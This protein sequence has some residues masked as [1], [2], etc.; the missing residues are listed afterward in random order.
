LVWKIILGIVLFFVIVLAVRVRVTVHS[1][2]GIS[3]CVKWLF[4]KFNILPKDK[5]KPKKEKKKK[6]KKEKKPKKED[7]E[8]EEKPKEES[9]KENIFLRFYHNNGVSGV[10]DLL[11]RLVASLKSGM[12]RIGR[13]FLF[14][15]IYVSLL[16][17]EGDSAATAD[18]YAK[19][20]AEIFP[21]MG[22][23][24][25]TMR[26]KKYSVDVNPDFI[27]GRSNARLH[28]TVSVRPLRLIN[29]FIALGCSLVFKV[30]IK[31]LKGSRSK[32]TAA[33]EEVKNNQNKN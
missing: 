10:V 29:A 6:K 11:K 23:I 14:E 32:K 12:K 15:E 7:E 18:K 17:G 24:V 16:V 26:V 22:F 13:A 30:L 9:G 3:L 1:E 27:Y 21:A 25:S 2:D 33:A 4:L 28:V 20:C 19:T 5:N 31:F 8:T